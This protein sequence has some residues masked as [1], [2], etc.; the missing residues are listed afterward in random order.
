MNVNSVRNKF[1]SIAEHVKDNIDV[2][3]ISETKSDSSFPSQQ[4]DIDNYKIFRRDRNCFGGGLMF[5]VTENIPCRELSPEQNDSNFEIIFLEITLRNNNWLL[6][7]LYKPPGQ[8][9][10]GFL[11]NLN[12][13]LNKYISKY[14]NIILIGDFSSSVENKHLADFTTLFNLE[15]LIKSPTCFQS[16][17]PTCIDLILTNKKELF[18]NSKKFEGG[19]SDH[20][21]LTLTSMRIQFVKSNP[22]VKFYRNYKSFNFES[23]NND[24]DGLLK[25]EINMNYSTFQNSFLQVLNTHAPVKKKVQRFNN[26]RF[27]TKQ[28]RKA[29][30]RCSRLKN[31]TIKQDLQKTGTIT[32]NSVIFV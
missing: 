8:K 20:Y 11:E 14:E 9:E 30:V 19:I 4:F 29:I 2:F 27:M 32:R 31:I 26:N 22:K 21:V 28:L 1:S 10:K 13:I 16:S 25:A 15:S 5:H 17:K 23:F 7:G 3:L 24:L 12:S 18:E 6:I